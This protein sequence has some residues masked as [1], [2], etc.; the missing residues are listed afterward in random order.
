MEEFSNAAVPGKYLAETFPLLNRLPLW[1]Q[2]WRKDAL[3]SFNRQAVIWMKYWNRLRK[4]MDQGEAPACFVKQF[5][6]TD[7]EK[8]GISELQA[9]FVAGSKWAFLKV[10][11]HK[12]TSN[13]GG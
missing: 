3:H 11:S 13:S 9:S 4:Q 6:E 8:N 10:A 12:D 1:M 7:F 2:W 5:I